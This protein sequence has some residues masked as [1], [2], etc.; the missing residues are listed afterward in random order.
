M[1]ATVEHVLDV[2]LDRLAD[3]PRNVRRNVGD[4]KDLTRSIP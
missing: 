2:P 3:H 4:L 1:T